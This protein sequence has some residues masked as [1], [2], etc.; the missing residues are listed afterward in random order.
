[1]RSTRRRQSKQARERKTMIE[2]TAG[3]IDYEEAGEGPTIVFVPGS[4]STGAAWRPV[5]SAL[6]GR[7]RCI[8]TSLLGYG[9]TAERRTP[10]DPSIAREA[11]IVEAVI[12]PARRPGHLVG[13]SFGG[14]TALA[15]AMRAKA[16]VASPTIAEAPAP[17]VLRAFGEREPYRTFR[18]MTDAYFAAFHRGDAEAIAMLIDFFAGPGAFAA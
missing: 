2:E 4:C 11:A 8:T 15:V 17:E 9:G 10:D 3:R 13:H 12:R 18:D 5:I 14:L 7:F 1:M 6:N 16:P